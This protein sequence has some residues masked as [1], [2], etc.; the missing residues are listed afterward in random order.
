MQEIINE[1]ERYLRK[2]I[3]RL[4][5]YVVLKEMKYNQLLHLAYYLDERA[6]KYKQEVYKEGDEVDYLYLVERG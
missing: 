4:K 6:F 3:D 5:T 1:D 2:N